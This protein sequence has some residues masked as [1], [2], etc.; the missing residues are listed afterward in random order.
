[1]IKKNDFL[2]KFWYK[3]NEDASAIIKK[4][5]ETDSKH[6]IRNENEVIVEGVQK[7]KQNW[8]IKI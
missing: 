7:K 1:M 2:Y 8:K 4:K 5:A 6:A 3:I